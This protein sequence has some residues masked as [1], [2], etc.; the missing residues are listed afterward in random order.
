M[1]DPAR[2]GFD[3]AFTA[4]FIGLVAGFWK[5]RSSLAVVAA[6]AVTAIVVE[7]VVPGAWYVLAGALAGMIAAAAPAPREAIAAP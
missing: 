1:G 2:Y 5:G 4:I 3:F 6:S 7:R